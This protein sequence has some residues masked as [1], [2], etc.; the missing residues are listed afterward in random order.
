MM[1]CNASDNVTPNESKW[2]V[3]FS[4]TI[5]K[6]LTPNLSGTHDNH[7]HHG[8]IGK[9]YGFGIVSTYGINNKLSISTFAGNNST[10]PKVGQLISTL[11]ADIQYII[12]RQHAALPLILHSAFALTSAY[13]G[14]V[15]K[16]PNECSNIVDLLE[17]NKCNT[18]FL[19]MSNYICED[20]ETL[21]FHQ[22]FDSSYTLLS[23][24]QWDMNTFLPYGQ[25]MSDEGNK[26]K[27]QMGTA[28]FLFRWTS[29]VLAEDEHSYFPITM[30][31]G[32]NILFT[33]FG[34][35]HR[36]H[37]TNKG[38]FFNYSSYQNRQY[39]HKTRKSVIR[40]LT[41]DEE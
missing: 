39:Y 10:D 1:A 20:A 8:S 3:P 9:Y 21:E 4:K 14:F 38:K 37:K 32:C 28:N 18:E 26:D 7:R 27:I 41:P 11:R 17:D 5:P 22:E 34:C 40:C 6:I 2:N 12:N 35:Y 23:V 19:S 29:N 15:S 30:S 16:Y 13:I 25:G 24:P 36:Q 31:P 33:G